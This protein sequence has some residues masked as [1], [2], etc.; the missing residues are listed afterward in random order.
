MRRVVARFEDEETASDAE[1]SLRKRDREP[2]RPEIDDAFF[3]PSARL[4]EARGLAWGGL[5]GGLLGAALLLAMAMDVVWIPRLS[6]LL[7]AGRLELAVFGFGAGAATGG[8]VGGLAGTYRDVPEPHGPRVAVAVPDHRVD[9][10]TTMLRGHGATTVDQTVLVHEHRHREQ[11]PAMS[12]DRRSGPSAGTVASAD[13]NP[14]TEPEAQPDAD[15]PSNAEVP[16]ES[17]RRPNSE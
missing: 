14:T 1:R 15:D 12:P 4:P 11:L 3:D 16:P 2:R 13:S 17:E 6:P 10:T 7:A 8:F 9:E 5:V